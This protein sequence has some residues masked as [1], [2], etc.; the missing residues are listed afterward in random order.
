MLSN[1]YDKTFTVINQIPSSKEDP[2]KKAWKKNVLTDCDAVGGIYDKTSGGIVY[3]INT[4]TVYCC[5]WKNYREPLFGSDGYYTLYEGDEKLYTAAV[6][7][8]IIFSAIDDAEPKSIAEFNALRD[9]YKNNGGIITACEAY[10]NYSPDGMPW[11]TNHI[12]IIKG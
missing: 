12:E 11:N 8:L 7:D 2:T 1:L 9:K 10:I 3:K 5:C 6:G 4:F